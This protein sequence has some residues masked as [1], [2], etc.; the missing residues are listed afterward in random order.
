MYWLFSLASQIWRAPETSFCLSCTSS[1]IRAPL[2]ERWPAYFI[3]L[4][5]Y[6]NSVQSFMSRNEQK[7]SSTVANRQRFATCSKT[8]IYHLAPNLS[9]DD[10]DV[11]RR[12]GE[13]VWRAR[14]AAVAD[15]AAND[16]DGATRAHHHRLLS[17]NHWARGKVGIVLFPQT[18]DKLHAAVY[19]LRV[20]RGNL[21]CVGS[22]L[23]R[24]FQL[25]HVVR[26]CFRIDEYCNKRYDQQEFLPPG[27][28]KRW[29]QR[30]FK[31][32]EDVVSARWTSFVVA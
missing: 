3:T 15:S 25:H 21:I 29:R 24:R 18:A 10:Y 2:I 32:L 16:D 8:C 17:A 13:A 27:R 1:R 6:R 14:Q 28:P 23:S 4:H 20:V 12:G 30:C 19:V 11:F 31:L 22:S 5:S 26:V 7:H 9:A